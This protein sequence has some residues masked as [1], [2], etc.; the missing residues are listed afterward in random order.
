MLRSLA[1]VLILLVPL[2][3]LAAQDNSASPKTVKLLTVGN[4][5]SRDATVYLER[6]AKARGHTLVHRPIVVGGAS[7]ALH[8]GRVETHEKDPKD[9]L[10][11]YAGKSLKQQLAED[12]WDFVTIQQ[13]SILSHNV[14]TYRP[15]AQKLR[16]YIKTHAP[17]AELL[18]HQTWAYRIDDP[19]FTKPSDK[20]GEPT[21]QKA[22]YDGLS[23]AYGTI[24]SEL[25]VRII[26]V[27]DAFYLADTDP[28]WGYKADKKFDFKNAKPPALPDQTHSLHVG[29]RWSKSKD[30]KTTL[31]IDG[32][33]ASPAGQYL[34]A[35]VFYERIFG[36]SVL[37]NPFV[38]AEFDKE[39]AAYL[40]SVAHR[41]V[42]NRDAK[43]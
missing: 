27:G 37:G 4:S 7:M 20:P 42:V 36:E 24:A 10:G 12:A 40:Q 43:K 19:R 28:K 22:M 41:A 18:L 26:P 8:S 33:H 14:E 5:F 3:R 31:S 2:P 25:G 16:D 15:Y 32:H 6:L 23:H 35:C 30:G 34:G 1:F 29:W 39:T 17:K 11:L 13:A 38:P 21:T 9:P